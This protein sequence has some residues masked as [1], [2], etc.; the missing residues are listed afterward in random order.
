MSENVVEKL[1]NFLKT[2]ALTV[3]DIGVVVGKIFEKKLM[4]E[5]DITDKLEQFLN[6][7][8]LTLGLRTLPSLEL[9]SKMNLSFS[10]D[11]F[12]VMEKSNILF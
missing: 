6:D 7:N 10:R 9:L 2:E 4:V 5:S 12:S 3:L 1:D 11:Y 8:E